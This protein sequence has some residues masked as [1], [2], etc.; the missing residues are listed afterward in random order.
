M[1]LSDG[2]NSTTGR[3]ETC[4]GSRWYTVCDKVFGTAEGRVTCRGLGYHADGELH[5][6]TLYIVYMYMHD[7]CYFIQSTCFIIHVFT[8]EI[9]SCTRTKA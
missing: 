6:H 9:W 2:T 7:V 3:V 5:V 8:Y 1:R 4:I